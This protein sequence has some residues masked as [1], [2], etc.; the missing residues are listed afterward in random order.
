MTSKAGVAS[1]Q[2]CAAECSAT[3]SVAVT[4]Y[5]DTCDVDDHLPM[6]IDQPASEQ[7]TV[8]DTGASKSSCAVETSV[9]GGLSGTGA[10][11]AESTSQLEKQQSEMDHLPSTGSVELPVSADRSGNTDQSLASGTAAEDIQKLTNRV[12][13]PLDSGTLLPHDETSS[14]THPIVSSLL[15]DS[16]AVSSASVRSSATSDVIDPLCADDSRSLDDSHQIIESLSSEITQPSASEPQMVC[17]C[18]CCSSDLLFAPCR[19]QPPDVTVLCYD[20]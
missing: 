20:F 19:L 8:E 17:H 16:A 6:M 4:S 7:I 5:T 10:A 15:A 2:S 18:L 12:P 1:N 11:D 13:N 14:S 3:S 9:S